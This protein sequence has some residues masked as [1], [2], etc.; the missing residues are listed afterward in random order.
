ML[1]LTLTDYGLKVT[2]ITE[3]NDFMLLLYSLAMRRLLL[4]VLRSRVLLSV[5]SELIIIRTPRGS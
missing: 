2:S 5:A 1:F 3:L 4:L